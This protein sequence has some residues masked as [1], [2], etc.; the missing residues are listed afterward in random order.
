MQTKGETLGASVPLNLRKQELNG[1][2]H[3]KKNKNGKHN[4]D[5]NSIRNNERMYI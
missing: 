4:T 2:L 1:I 3:G 5:N